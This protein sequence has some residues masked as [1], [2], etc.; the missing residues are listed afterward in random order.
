MNSFCNFTE[1][2]E[3]VHEPS[4]C[5]KGKLDP[6]RKYNWLFNYYFGPNAHGDLSQ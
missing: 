2:S 3:S 1:Y 4:K 6:S 5:F